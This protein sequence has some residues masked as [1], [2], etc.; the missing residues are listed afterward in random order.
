MLEKSA[1]LSDVKTH[2]EP[3]IALIESHMPGLD[4]VEAVRIELALEHQ[5][6]RLRRL[7]RPLRR[8]HTCGHEPWNHGATGPCDACHP[9]GRIADDGGA[10]P[11]GRAVA[12]THLPVVL[13]HT[14]AILY[15][16]HGDQP[17][18]LGTVHKMLATIEMTL[19]LAI[20]VVGIHWSQEVRG[21]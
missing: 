9:D 1:L 16:H 14:R 2:I 7:F 21:G 17:P 5:R 18:R 20:T 13:H 3:Q 8:R 12:G 15:R 11:C 10:E 4:P 6:E 19:T